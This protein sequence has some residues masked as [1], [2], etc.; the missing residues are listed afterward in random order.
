MSESREGISVAARALNDGTPPLPLGEANIKLPEETLLKENE[1]V[2]VE[3]A[4]ATEVE[5]S[6]ERLPELKNVTVPAPPVPL[7]ADVICPFEFTVIFE[8]V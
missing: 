7:E 3:V 2:G 4:V 1:S 5:N 8:L 6:G